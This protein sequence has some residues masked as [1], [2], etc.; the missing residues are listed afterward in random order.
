MTGFSN[1]VEAWVNATKA[2]KTAVYRRSIELLAEEMALT[3]AQ[4][5]KV[6]FMT[7][8]LARSL[9]ASTSAM[10]KT[11][12]EFSVGS[13][14]GTITAKL[15]LSQPVWIG[16][17]AVYARRVNYGFVGADKIGRVYNQAGAYFVEYA[18]S[19][20]PTIV[21]LAAEEVKSKVES[22]SK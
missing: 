6:P 21:E 14:I 11:S 9:L 15:K 12:E 13:S 16:Y 1:Q 2:R 10:P 19:V 3:R 18:I 20:W 7:G 17:Q 5:G 4:G 8:N 22:R